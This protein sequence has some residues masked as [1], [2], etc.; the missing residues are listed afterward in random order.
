MILQMALGE[1]RRV[2]RTKPG[3]GNYM[4]G[5][6]GVYVVGKIER[7]GRERPG[8]TEA[9]G[10]IGTIKPACAGKVLGGGRRD[11]QQGAAWPAEPAI[12]EGRASHGTRQA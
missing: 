11:R 6:D 9:G 2:R 5:T 12:A 10:R 3:V 1:K 4:G 7:K 8:E